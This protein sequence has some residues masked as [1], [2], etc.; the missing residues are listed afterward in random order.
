MHR[1]QHNTMS[2][3]SCLDLPLPSGAQQ[4][5][6]KQTAV[7]GLVYLGPHLFEGHLT[8]RRQWWMSN[9]K[10]LDMCHPEEEASGTGWTAREEG[11]EGKMQEAY[12]F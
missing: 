10:G 2:P 7:R 3:A 9:F 1:Q 11:E 4:M 5:S 8:P 6:T 12:L